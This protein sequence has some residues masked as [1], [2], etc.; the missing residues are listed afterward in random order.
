VLIFG[1][2]CNSSL[3]LSCLIDS[4]FV[5]CRSEELP[6]CEARAKKTKKI[7]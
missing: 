6:E 7:C 5:A 1:E 2:L 4:Q 3:S